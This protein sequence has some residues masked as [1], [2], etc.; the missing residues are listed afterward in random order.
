MSALSKS[1]QKNAQ[2][3]TRS[4]GKRSTSSLRAN[5]K[6]E[7]TDGYVS[8]S[9]EELRKL[10]SQSNWAKF[11]SL[12][13]ED[14]DRSIADDPDWKGL[15]E[16]DWSKAEIVEPIGKQAISIRL[17]QDVLAFFKQAGTGYQSRI[18]AVLKSY[19]SATQKRRAKKA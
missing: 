19:V 5:G 12:T 6:K 11:D 1:I 16:I 17:D 3:S 2:S 18:N 14:I 13:D 7:T 4:G 10:P 8:Y 9:I 15:E